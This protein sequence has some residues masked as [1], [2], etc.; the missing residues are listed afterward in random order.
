M[1]DQGRRLFCDRVK[2][3]PAIVFR[4][5]RH[6]GWARDA[7]DTDNDVFDERE[8]RFKKS[9]GIGLDVDVNDPFAYAIRNADI[10]FPGMQI[11]TAAILVLPVAKFHA[12]AFLG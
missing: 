3:P 5:A 4:S 12:V 10:H 6:K 11:D 9:L 8:H 2:N 1:H 7:F